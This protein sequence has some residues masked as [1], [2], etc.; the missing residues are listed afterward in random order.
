[1][2]LTSP[3][4][5]MTFRFILAHLSSTYVNK[6]HQGTI[7]LRFNSDKRVIPIGS[8]AVVYKHSSQLMDLDDDLIM[9]STNVHNLWCSH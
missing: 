5:Q 4:M 2:G 9:P 6:L 1:M 3:S 8:K 7:D